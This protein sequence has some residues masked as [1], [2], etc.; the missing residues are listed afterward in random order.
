M[1]K[2]NRV[3]VLV[4]DGFGVGELPDAPLFGDVGS[5]T[6]GH[7][8][9][10]RPNLRIP[11]LESLG[12][13]NLIGE[14]TAKPGACFTKMKEISAGKDTTTGH[15]EM[16]GLPVQRGF[17]TFPQ[18]FPIDFM[19]EFVGS[20]QLD[21]YLGN[22]PASGTE[23]IAHLGLEHTQTLKPIV[24]T[25]ADSVFQ[26]AAHESYFGLD[27]L[28]EICRKTRSLLNQSSYRVAR[29]IARPFVGEKS[30]TFARTPRRKDFSVKPFSETVLTR[31]KSSS[32]SVKAIGKI[33]SIYDGEGITQSFS[34]ESD[35]EGIE[36]CAQI[37]KNDP[38]R[39]LIF[40]NLNDLD[41]LYGHRRNLAGYATQLEKID[42]WLPQIL[43]SLTDSDLLMITSDHGNDPSFK[44][45]DHTREY[46]PLLIHSPG[47]KSL[48]LTHLDPRESF[49]DL[50]QSILE[51]F[52]LPPTSHGT[53]FL[54]ELKS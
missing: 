33:S 44:G 26:I 22:Y 32:F 46:V 40:C 20:N 31:L 53:S 3:L 15:W 1:T 51:N 18:G 29:V 52:N 50:G 54:S 24:Y 27:R 12:L 36:I 35:E 9:K 23:I 45:T 19:K 41:M 5:D 11:H 21:G 14:D 43:Q 49:C 13:K 16:M 47:L 2:F 30:E 39:G 6:F 7:L 28:Y 38:A 37:L 4:L 8:L 10:N 48:D 34:T 42:S 17:D 25:S